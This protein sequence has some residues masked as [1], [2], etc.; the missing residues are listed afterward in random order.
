[1]IGAMGVLKTDGLQV[2]VVVDNTSAFRMDKEV[3]LVVPEVNEKALPAHRG[4]I[5]DPTVGLYS[6]SLS[7]V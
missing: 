3:P 6:D 4:I 5:A 2:V 1:M 7:A